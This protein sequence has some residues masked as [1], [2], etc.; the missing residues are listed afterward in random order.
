MI[1][2]QLSNEV[3]NCLFLTVSRGEGGLNQLAI[4]FVL[5]LTIVII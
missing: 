1:S 2:Y 4:V 3:E 5:L